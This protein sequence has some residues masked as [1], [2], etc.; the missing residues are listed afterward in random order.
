MR[1]RDFITIAS[2]AAAWPLAARAQEPFPVIGFLSTRSQGE[3]ASAVDAFRQ[4]LGQNGYVEGKNVII[5]YRWADGQYDRL[6][7]LAADLVARKVA[8]ITATGG[9]P[10]P[11]AAKAATSTIPIVFTAGG[12][13]VEFGLVASL[14]RPGGNVTGVTFFFAELGPKR[15]ELVR[16][17]N[18][19]AKTVAM[20]INPTYQPGPVEARDVQAG[21]LSLGLQINVLNAGTEDQI[22]TAFATITQQRVDA[23]IVGTDPFLLGRRDQLVRLA[24]HHRVPTVYFTH[25]FV[26]AGGL[27]SYGPSIA[28]GYRQAG[29]Y[30]GRI[31][32]G[33]KA[34]DLPVLQPT[35]FVLFINLKTARALGLDLPQTLLALADEVIE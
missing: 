14:G 31:L 5:E 11:L 33:E 24:A 10:S 28:D 3:A 27:V 8:V 1:R 13:P 29:S 18:P 34:G 4:G 7:A 30:V 22:D 6:P 20:L 26:D 21:A 12:N 35:Q 16:R 9:E 17:L 32:K 25:E 2:G 23:L 19:N 15:L